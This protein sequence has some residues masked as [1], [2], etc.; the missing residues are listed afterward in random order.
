MGVA[1]VSN[2]ARDV[3]MWDR[4]HDGNHCSVMNY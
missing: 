2:I 1:A 4:F 3:L